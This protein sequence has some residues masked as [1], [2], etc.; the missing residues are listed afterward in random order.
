MSCACSALSAC[1]CNL[2]FELYLACIGV[3]VRVGLRDA[4]DGWCPVAWYI[5]VWG[6]LVR[7]GVHLRGGMVHTAGPSRGHVNGAFGGIFW[8]TSTGGFGASL[9]F[10]RCTSASPIL[11]RIPMKYTIGLG[12]RS[13]A[14]SQE[15]QQRWHWLY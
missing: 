6:C 4:S 14:D 11:N 7:F 13:S 3:Q 15:P 2:F 5:G 8:N 12:H 9:A 10:C 1:L